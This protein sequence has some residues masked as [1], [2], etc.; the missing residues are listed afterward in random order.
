[1]QYTQTG[2]SLCYMYTL[3][4]LLRV[5]AWVI[6]YVQYVSNTCKSCA[7]VL[8]TCTCI[9]YACACLYIHCTCVCMMQDGVYIYGS[10]MIHW[11]FPISCVHVRVHVLFGER[12]S[13]LCK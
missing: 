7:H 9:I 4:V 2:V 8:Y 3:R 6:V 10:D 1:M 12:Q 13:C 5:T 11:L